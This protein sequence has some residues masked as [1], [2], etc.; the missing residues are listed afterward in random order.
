MDFIF[1][2][3]TVIHKSMDFWCVIVY[4]FLFVLN[5]SYFK[6]HKDMN[7]YMLESLKVKMKELK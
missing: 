4:V 7:L 3:I 1:I 6:R 5:I 2:F